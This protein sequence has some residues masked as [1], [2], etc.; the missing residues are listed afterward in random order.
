MSTPEARPAATVALVRAGAAGGN[1]ALEVLLVLRHAKMAF[2]GQVWV[3]PGG[4][5]DA[6][7]GEGDLGARRAAVRET[8]EE[9]GIALGGPAD[10]IPF[11]RWVTPHSEPRRF[12]TMFYLVEVARGWEVRLAEDELSAALWLEP[13]DALARHARGELALAPPTW[14]TLEGLRRAGAVEAARAWAHGEALRGLAPLT[15]T[16]AL[17]GGGVTVSVPGDA[18]PLP[19]G[20]VVSGRL[21]MRRGVW[22]PG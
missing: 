1:G 11:A 18:L 3:F 20:D 6:D 19:P 2:M 13:A 21:V 15:P 17:E 10:L 14:W 5:V 7:D 12:D 9:V 16:L 8:L 22:S 4:K